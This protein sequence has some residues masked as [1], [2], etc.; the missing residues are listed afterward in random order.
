MRGRDIN[1]KKHRAEKSLSK[2]GKRTNV[3][4]PNRK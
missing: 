1:S 3:G 4:D 2:H